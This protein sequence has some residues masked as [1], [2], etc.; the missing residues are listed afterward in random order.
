MA[1]ITKIQYRTTEGNQEKQ[2]DIGV[3]SDNVFIE[4]NTNKY[5]LTNIFA[6][7]KN[8]FTNGHFIIQSKNVPTNNNVVIWNQIFNN[9]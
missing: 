3:K 9:E 4:D 2:Y 5:T 8:F 1:V 6:Y 7:L